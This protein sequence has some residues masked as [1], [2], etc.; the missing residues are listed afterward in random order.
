LV[1]SADIVMVVT[2]VVPVVGDTDSQLGVLDAAAVNATCEPVEVVTARFCASTV[3]EFTELNADKD[4]ACKVNAG[5]A[6]VRLTVTVGVA[7]LELLQTEVELELE[8]AL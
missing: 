6:T 5:G 1:G 7:L 3:E 4:E 2:P 8:A